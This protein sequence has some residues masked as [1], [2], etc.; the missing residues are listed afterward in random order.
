[1]NWVFSMT[2]GEQR[3]G[4]KAGVPPGL[5]SSPAGKQEGCS[6]KTQ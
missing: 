4:V 2:S 5:D 3:T 1:M 6:G